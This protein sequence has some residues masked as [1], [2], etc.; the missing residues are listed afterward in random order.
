M[1]AMG[2]RKYF[3]LDRRRQARVDS[4]LLLLILLLLLK[5]MRLRTS[6]SESKTSTWSAYGSRG[7]GKETEAVPD[8]QKRTCT[9]HQPKNT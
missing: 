9:G 7:T 6:R 1:A 2:W 3:S 4:K 8:K 5:L